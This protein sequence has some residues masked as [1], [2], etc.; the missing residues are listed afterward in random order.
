MEFQYH[1]PVNLMFGRGKVACVG[2]VAARYGKRAVIVT[3]GSSS[4]KSGLLDKVMSFL[5]AAGVKSAVFDKASQNPLTTTAR[6]GAEFAKEFGCDCVVALGGGSIMDCA[7]AVAFLAVN[8]GDVNDYI[9]NLI[10]GESALPIIA[11]PTTCGTGSEGNGFAVL[12]NPENGDKKSLRRD[13]IIPSLSIIDSELM[14]TMPKSVLSSVGFDALCHSMEAY[15]S[16]LSQPITEYLS[17]QGMKLI[18]ENLA[19]IYSG[20]TDPDK[21]DSV[22]WASTIGGMV[23]NTAGVALPHGMEHPASGLKNIVHGRGLAALTPVI[24][25]A[26]FAAAKEKYETIAKILGEKSAC[27]CGEGIR[28]LLERIDLSVTLSEQGITADDIPW[29]TENCF[30]VSAASIKNHPAVF[31]KEA[32]ARLYEQAL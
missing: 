4:K 1:L 10:E 19:D 16:K 20:C 7:K 28:K 22:T 5:E 31:N 21:W 30:K 18:A 23:I 26:S 25:D 13:S 15:L 8:A 2:E 3:G 24:T 11:V 6:E 17:L 29:M 27:D 12:T 32:V 9:Y 14:Q